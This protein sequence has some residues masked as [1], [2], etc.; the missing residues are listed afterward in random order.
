MLRAG[1]RNRKVIIERAT[2]S[3]EVIG[4]PK[5]TWA[6]LR[7]EWA[8]E[9]PIGGKEQLASGREMSTRISRFNFLYF[10]NVTEKDRLNYDGRYWDIVAIRPLGFNEGLEITAEARA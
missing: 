10:T 1:R 8:E 6:T 9:I 4:A 3:E 7:T 2:T 5:K